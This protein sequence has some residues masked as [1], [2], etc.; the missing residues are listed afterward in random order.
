M[1]MCANSPRYRRNLL[2]AHMADHQIPRLQ[3]KVLEIFSFTLMLGDLRESV[4]VF[5]AFSWLNW[6][7]SIVIFLGFLGQEEVP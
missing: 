4:L 3:R 1:Y 7:C 2:V 5:Y 6:H